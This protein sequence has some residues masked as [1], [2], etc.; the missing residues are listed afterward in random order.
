MGNVPKYFHR[1]VNLQP[2]GSLASLISSWLGSFMQL[3]PLQVGFNNWGASLL[4]SRYR[5]PVRL[6]RPRS[7][8]KSSPNQLPALFAGLGEPLRPSDIRA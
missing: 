8:L 1:V 7:L 4:A 3:V 2:S 5:R 6:G